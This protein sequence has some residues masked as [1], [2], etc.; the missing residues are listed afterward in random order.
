MKISKTMFRNFKGKHLLALLLLSATFAFQCNPPATVDKAASELDV[1]IT[2]IDSDNS[3]SDGKLPVIMQFFLDGKYVKLA[4]NA[5]VTCNGVALTDNG[6]GP[7]ERVALV[8]PGGT[9]TFRHV[10]SGVTTTAVVTVPARPVITSPAVN[11]TVARTANVTITYT[12]GTGQSMMGS[13]SNSSMSQG[14]TSQPDNGTYSGLNATALT[15]GPGTVSI[16]RE[17]VNNMTTGFKSTEVKY[18]SGISRN[19]N[20][21]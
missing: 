2:V 15:A 12:P 6:L 9:Y 17:F 19:V 3:T 14:G 4:G 16:R 8:S 10:R 20:W 21:N 13:V 5:T 18:T 7:A 1:K 11:A